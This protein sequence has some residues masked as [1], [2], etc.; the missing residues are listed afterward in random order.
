[1]KKERGIEEYKEKGVEKNANWEKYIA[2]NFFLEEEILW[3]T[4]IHQF[5]TMIALSEILKSFFKII[6]TLV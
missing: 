4:D 2:R 5:Y 3:Y 1:M 6:I